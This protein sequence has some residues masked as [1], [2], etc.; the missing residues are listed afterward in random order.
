MP[1][2]ITLTHDYPASARDV[3][4]IATD[5]E[6]YREAMGRLIAFDGL[7]K[8]TIEEG[9]RIDVRVSLFGI[10]PWQDYSM[11]VESC[12]HA[13]MEFQSDEHGAGIDSWRH[14]LTVTETPSGSRLTDTVE[15][16][17]GVLTPFFAWWAGVVYRARHKPR[18][19]MLAE[20]V[21]A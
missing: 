6:S 15:V 19:R 3:W 9:Q 21:P 17:A 1:R 11:T 16:D 14:H 2:T 4:E 5:M 20:R 8:G 7:P 18:L 13:A 10:G 12:D